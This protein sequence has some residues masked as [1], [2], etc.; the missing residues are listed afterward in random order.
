MKIKILSFLA[1]SALLGM[2]LI[3]GCHYDEILPDINPG[4]EVSFSEDIVPLFDASC[5]S[6]GCHKTGGIAPDLTADNAYNALINGNYIDVTNPETS[7]LYQWVAGNR[8]TP[9]PI[10]GTDSKIVSAVLLWIEQ[11]ALDN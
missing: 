2:G 9:M 5:N 6:S 3:S 10:S 1:L 8:T 4:D 11:G 7:E